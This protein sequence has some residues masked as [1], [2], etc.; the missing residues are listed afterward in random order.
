MG[1]GVSVIL[2]LIFLVVAASAAIC[3][4]D[5]KLFNDPADLTLTFDEFLLDYNRHPDRFCCDRG[6]LYYKLSRDR[7]C[8]VVSF[9][10]ESQDWDELCADDRI[11]IG[12]SLRDFFKYKRWRK[13]QKQRLDFVHASQRKLIYKEDCRD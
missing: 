4:F 7:I 13:Q 9:Y 5:W 2:A 1:K 3:F 12:L 10:D 8:R 6:N 11:Y